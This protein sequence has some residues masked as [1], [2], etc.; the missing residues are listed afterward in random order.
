MIH[1]ISNVLDEQAI[2][3]IISAVD[4]CQ[5]QD[6]KTTA[7]GMAAA[8]K[9]NL[10]LTRK[11][12]PELIEQI[13]KAVARNQTFQ[14]IAMPRHLCRIMV[15]G[16]T[17]GMEYGAHSDSAVMDGFRVDLSFTLFL[18]DPASYEGGALAID[19][20]FGE[21]KIKLKPGALVLYQTGTLHRVVP[22]SRGVRLAAVGWVQSRIRDPQRR[23]ILLDLEAAR[24]YYF[25]K[26]GHDRHAELLLKT[27]DNLMRMWDD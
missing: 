21:R 4:R 17:E 12:A 27:R 2:A 11:E 23:E 24:Q 19:T 13:T 20:E 8:V 10:Q 25:E 3:A 15:S 14:A 16:Y 1:V 22:V 26:V 18:S 6:G 5:M 7:S 9:N